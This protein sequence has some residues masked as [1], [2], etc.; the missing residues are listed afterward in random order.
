MNE[1]SPILTDSFGRKHSYLRISLSER[2]NLRCTYCMP[3][4]G[5]MLSPKECLMSSTE[6]INLATLF[7]EYGVNRIR[8]T[9]GEPLLRKDIVSIVEGLSQLDVQLSI[10]TNAVLMD[11]FIDPF[12]ELGLRQIN[13]SLDTLDAER[14][15][16]ITLR[17]QFQRT[18]DN[19]FRMLDAGF[20]VKLNVVLMKEQNEEEIIPFIELTRNHNLAVRF[21][22]FMPFSGN[23]WD[24][25]R[26]VP[27]EQILETADAEYGRSAVKAM[28]LGANFT[29]RNFQ[30]DGFKGHFGIIS[31]VTNPFCD[32]CNRLRLT[33]NG[34]LKNCL[35]SQGETDLLTP[36]RQG[37]PVEAIIR[38][39]VYG[40]KAARG[41]MMESEDFDQAVKH[42]D[43]RSM[44]A[45]GG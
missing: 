37:M 29:A 35:F 23:Q 19:L 39:A 36:Y 21:I 7:A 16:L 14:F 17:D 13:V 38:K 18:Y 12:K 26:V 11:R 44:I 9:G 10:T 3:A 42:E 22:E 40:K 1:V 6:V 2:C 28:P 24:R 5:L 31:T 32:S 45:I 34:R 33:A 30:I 15:E 20:K 8:L 25:S 4:E 27:Q 41:G 43:N